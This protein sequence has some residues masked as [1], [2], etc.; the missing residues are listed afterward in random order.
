MRDDCKRERLGERHHERLH[1]KPAE[2][3]RERRRSDE[4]D[5]KRMIARPPAFAIRDRSSHVGPAT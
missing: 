4:H 3:Q 2:H 5:H 1:E